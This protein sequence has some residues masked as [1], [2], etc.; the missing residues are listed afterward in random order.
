MAMDENELARIRA[1]YADEAPDVLAWR[2]DHVRES[3][4]DARTLLA[5]VGRLR[6][7]RAALLDLWIVENN[8]GWQVRSEAVPP[9]SFATREEAEEA[10][11]KWASDRKR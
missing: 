6:A 11:L 4:R 8:G 9:P 3:W 5:E 1:R 10:V 2:V 7:D